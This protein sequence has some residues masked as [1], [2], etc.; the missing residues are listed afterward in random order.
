MATA[1]RIL[2]YLL[3]RDLRVSDNPVFHEISRLSSQASPPFTHILPVYVYSAN[4]IEVSGFLRSRDSKSP[5]PEARAQN[6]GFWRTGYHR[7]KFVSQSVWDV[8]GTL[9]QLGSG[10]VIRVGKYVDVVRDILQH[11]SDG[12]EKGEIVGVW[13]TEDT[14]SEEKAQERAVRKE[15]EKHGKEFKLWLDEKYFVDHRDLPF[16][17]SNIIDLPDVY[18]TFR[19]SVEPLRERPRPTHPLPEKLPPLPASIP[20]QFE[21][22]AIPDG[23]EALQEALLSPLISKPDIPNPPSWPSNVGSAHPFAGG[24]TKGQKRLHHLLKSGAASAYKDTRNGLLGEDFSTK[25][26]AYLSIGCLSARQVHAAMLQF[27]DGTPPVLPFF[28]SEET[29]WPS[30]PGWAGGENKGTAAIRFEL[31]WRDYMRLCAQKFNTALFTIH[32]FR[33]SKLSR[34][35]AEAGADLQPYS[36][37]QTKK[38]WHYLS[39]SGPGSSPEITRRKLIRFIRGETGIGLIDASQRELIHTGYTSNRARQNVASFLSSHLNI[40]WRLGAEWYEAMLVDYDVGSNW[41]NWQYVAGVGNDPRLGRVFNPVKQALDYDARGEY[42]R[43]WVDELRGVD[44]AAEPSQS[45]KNG[46]PAKDKTD[47]VDPEKLMGVYQAWRLRDAEKARLG[48]DKLEWVQHPLTRINFSVAGKGRFPAGRGGG[49]RG[50]RGG[51]GGRGTWNARGRGD[52]G[53]RRGNMDRANLAGGGGTQ[54]VLPE[55]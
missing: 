54:D 37:P 25:L 51:G 11:Y 24:E 23:E 45:A 8:K 29:D 6:S 19:K 52:R 40:D 32:G 44:I 49:N 38:E 18:T 48:L 47:D 15:T 3:R 35:N 30:V 14:G 17:I 22:F 28:P 33:G 1:P 4:Q 55:S 20:S 12:G 36:N 16:D 21:P 43:A 46:T 34:A 7:A 13:M 39:H 31:L 41:G 26:S 50:G 42:V 2:V 5:Y 9:G 10:L 27:E 53:R